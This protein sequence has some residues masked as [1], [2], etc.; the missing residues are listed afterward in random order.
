M[1][2]ESNK[3]CCEICSLP[4]SM[5]FSELPESAAST[6]S[7]YCERF[8]RLINTLTP[9]L[10]C[11]AFC[12]PEQNFSLPLCHKPTSR[13]VHY[14]FR[15][16]RCTSKRRAISRRSPFDESHQ[17][18]HCF[19]LLRLTNLQISPFVRLAEARAAPFLSFCTR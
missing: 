5:H 18:N 9:N 6:N 11:I 2:F 1:L 17:S 13:S 8:G 12:L 7:L 15:F 10:I 19:L 4:K 14:H 16:H 3:T